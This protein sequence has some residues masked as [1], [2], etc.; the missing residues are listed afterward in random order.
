MRNLTA[1][2]NADW[3]ASEA[4]RRAAVLAIVGAVTSGYITLRSLDDQLATSQRTLASRR[5]A[6]TVF[7]KR[8]K[9]GVISGVEL[10]QAQY[11]YE[12]AAA[13]MPVLQQQIAQQENALSILV[14][15][16]PGAIARGKHLLELGTP[17]CP[18]NCRP[19]SSRSGPTW[20]PPSSRSLPRT[21]G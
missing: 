17:A 5:Q 21:R 19:R 20:S 18:R 15:R 8:H 12:V 3:R 10:S 2:A 14:G 1:A 6:L 16:N 13:A 4:D 7:E 11:Q 9:G